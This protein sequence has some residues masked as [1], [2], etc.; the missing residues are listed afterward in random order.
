MLDEKTPSVALDKKVRSAMKTE[1]KQL[2]KELADL[3]QP[4]KNAGIP[5]ILL[6]EGW[7][8]SGKGSAIAKVISE[9]DPRNYQ[10]HS[11]G[12]PSED[13]L[14]HPFLWS[15]W[16][17]LPPHGQFAIFDRSWY[18]RCQNH[19]DHQYV[20]D[21]VAIQDFERQLADD[22]YLILKFFLNIS[23]TEQKRRLE[24]LAADSATAWRVTAQDWQQNRNFDQLRAREDTMLES[25]NSAY[26]P[27]H[28]IWNEEKSTG[29]LE[30]LRTVRD[31]LQTA[32]KQGAPRPVKA[33][34]KQWPLLT[35]P[36]LSDVDLTP[37]I[38]ETEYRKA[39]KKEKK[40]LQELHSR[41]YRERIPVIL[42]F[43]GWDAAGKGGAIRRLSWA[44]DPRSFEVVPIAAPSPD[45]L[46][47]HYLWR[48]WTRLPKDGHVAL[49]DRSWYG[50][51]MV[52]RVENL[53]PESRW[54][55]A[56]NEINEF[57]QQLHNWGAVILKFWIHID[58][59]TQLERFHARE[60]TPEKQYKITDEDWR[61]R[62]KWPA[63]EVAVNEMLQKTSTSYAPWIIIP[64]NDKKYARLQVMRTVRKALTARLAK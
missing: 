25:T 4:L 1:I 38:T 48:F 57:E 53:T 6:F 49:F 52:E 24:K 21:L 20:Q 59:D 31:A 39:L 22:G 2:Q 8:A 61:N 13:A 41:I 32:L 35:M 29:L 50:R 46:A 37:T 19:A 15:F 58:Q 5:V 16:Q 42:C 60:S 12:D 23:Q 28:V 34:S 62:A 10:V 45:A 51:V 43:E 55:M 27:W 40:K 56:Y 36:R 3:Q 17:A 9:L 18:R 63:Y 11:F 64:G 30:I 44:L 7:S 47:H 14:R 54:S 26:A 33:E